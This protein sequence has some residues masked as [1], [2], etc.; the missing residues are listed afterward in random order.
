MAMIAFAPTAS[1]SSTACSIPAAG[2]VM[3]TSSGDSG[4]SASDV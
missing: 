3:T 2:T 4:S 1:E